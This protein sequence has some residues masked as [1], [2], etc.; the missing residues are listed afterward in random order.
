M[1]KITVSKILE[2][3]NQNFDA[4]TTK[5][6]T[7]VQSATKKE[8]AKENSSIDADSAFTNWKSQFGTPLFTGGSF[9]I[10]SEVYTAI[11][12]QVSAG[13]DDSVFEK[14]YSLIESQ[15]IQ[16]V[17]N[18]IGTILNQLDPITV[19]VTENGKKVNYVVEFTGSG[20]G[21]NVFT[22]RK[23]NSSAILTS[24]NS[25][26]TNWKKAMAKYCIALYQLEHDAIN[27]VKKEC[28]KIFATNTID[29]VKTVIR[30]V[31]ENT[32]NSNLK[33]VLTTI[34]GSDTDSDLKKFLNS[35]LFKQ[36]SSEYLKIEIKNALNNNNDKTTA[37]SLDNYQTLT[38]YYNN[39]ID[40]VANNKGESVVKK[41]VDD[42]NTLAKSMLGGSFVKVPYP[43][44]DIHYSKDLAS[45]TIPASYGHY[46]ESDD[47]ES[48]VKKIYAT[49]YT[50]SVN[51]IGNKNANVI[52]SGAGSDNL[53]GG[54]GK[55]TIFGGTGNDSI[56]GE[57]DADKLYGDA[58]NDTLVGGLG[59]DT[60]TGGAG[61]DVFVY[62]DGDG[63]DTVLDYVSGED[64]IKISSGSISSYSVSGGK[65]AV[66]KVGKGKITLKGVG[67]NQITV[68]TSDNKTV[69]YG[70]IANGLTFNKA[71]LPKA[72][73]ATI[74]SNYSGQFDAGAYSS[75]VTINASSRTNAVE[76]VGN[77]K[78]N[79]IQGG[80]SSDILSG[81]IGKDT[82]YGGSGNDSLYGEKDADKL[83]G[84]AGNDTLVGGL[85][86]DTLT[87][88]AGKDVFYYSNGDG[89]D[90]IADFTVNEDKIYISGATSV[91]GSL[92]KNDVTF[93]VGKGSIKVQNTKDKEIIIQYSNGTFSKY[94]NGKLIETY[95]VES[96][97]NQI[98]IIHQFV[99]SLDETNLYGISAVN[100]AI[101]ACSKYSGLQNLID[102][103]ISDCQNAKNVDDFLKNYC[104]INLDNEDTGAITGKDA[105]GHLTQTAVSVVPETSTKYIYPNTSSITYKGLTVNIPSKSS[106]N[107]LQQNI[108]AGL[109]TWWL[110]EGLDIVEKSYGLTFEE[111]DISFKAVDFSFQNFTKTKINYLT[112][113]DYGYSEWWNGN[114][115]VNKF[116]TYIDSKFFNS[117]NTSTADGKLVTSNGSNVLYLDRFFTV[118]LAFAAQ[119]ANIKY[120]NDLPNFIKW[121]LPVLSVGGDDI[122]ENEIRELASD[123]KKLAKYV[124]TSNLSSNVEYDWAGGYMLLRYLAKQSS[125]DSVS[126]SARVAEDCW[127]V[128]DDN[129]VTNDANV[130]SIIEE[131]YSVT[132]IETSDFNS[133]TNE[134]FILTCNQS[135]NNQ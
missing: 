122:Y 34:G 8:L 77:K 76:I 125:S 5:I 81:G 51:I 50:S 94:L 39:L 107:N 89:A 75:L 105:G 71:D 117:I 126:L 27:K 72:T 130:D 25:N 87:G 55:D 46:V 74:N 66:L 67:N 114:S 24:K 127:F 49:T 23:G 129:F 17:V 12:K 98:E 6:A 131:N 96:D 124:S 88:G 9:T 97:S 73:S 28:L 26:I 93:K 108:V 115:N 13:I 14:S 45:V 32:K 132:N 44:D 121:G 134:K 79:K 62:S 20:I 30:V 116:A 58:G 113:N 83:Y 135:E 59:K 64:K 1:A 80:S 2:A 48:K 61:S 4:I 112:P 3:A 92:N 90:I 102:N 65:D 7:N 33:K 52:Y 43:S 31:A 57:S 104:G 86:N 47:Y 18:Q 69:T 19:P 119:A 22:V 35:S 101:K 15:T 63:D 128:E 68:I 95:Y 118:N 91:T 78:A 36:I 40:V 60:I 99:K 85:G 70:G 103:F 37:N 133:L 29:G 110:K 42:F 41:A 56:Y 120:Y 84:D 38:T 111:S 21:Q 53:Y 11:A 10:P 16:T 106:L 109:N 54:I 82:L 123:S 100:E